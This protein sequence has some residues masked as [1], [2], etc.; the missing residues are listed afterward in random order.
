MHF[1]FPHKKIAILFA[2]LFV[3]VCAQAKSAKDSSNGEAG[4]LLKVGGGGYTCFGTLSYRYPHF[5]SIPV[6][7][8]LKTKNNF[9]FGVDFMTFLG[10]KVNSTNLLY[11]IGGND[12]T[13][14]DVDGFPTLLRYYMRG[15]SITATAGKLFSLKPGKESGK[16]QL[17]FGVGFMQHKTKIQFDKG[18]TP[19]LDGAY[20]YG[21]DRLTNGL[22]LTQSIRYHYLNTE[23]LSVFF[24]LDFSQGFTK[25]QRNWDSGF[26]NA[27]AGRRL[28]LY[29]GA[30]AGILIPIMFKTP[31]KNP[32]YF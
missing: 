13:V 16:L 6:A 10:S 31:T 25:A 2:L 1:H 12:G 30:S 23:T 26:G 14:L 24:G 5:A 9:T 18:K 22:Q 29:A 21:Y 19:Q 17:N 8:Y 32:G 4:I 28:D 20:A 15:Y 3:M 27:D 11:G 7:A